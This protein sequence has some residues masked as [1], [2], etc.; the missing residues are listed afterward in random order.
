MPNIQRARQRKY[1][2]EF[3]EVFDAIKKMA[4]MANIQQRLDTIKK[5]GLMVKNS[6]EQ[7]KDNLNKNGNLCSRQQLNTS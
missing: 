6:T 1:I 2:S 5:R 4:K 7:L 3:L